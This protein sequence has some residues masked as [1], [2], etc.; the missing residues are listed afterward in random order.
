M[1]LG[2]P[3]GDQNIFNVLQNN[4]FRCHILVSTTFDISEMDECAI[5]SLQMCQKGKDI[6][7]S[8]FISKWYVWF[9]ICVPP[10]MKI[11]PVL[12]YR[13]TIPAPETLA[14]AI[15]RKSRSFG[16]RSV[17]WN[18]CPEIVKVAMSIMCAFVSCLHENW[19]ADEISDG[20]T[21]FIIQWMLVVSDS[22][23]LSMNWPF[24]IMIE[25]QAEK[26]IL[27]SA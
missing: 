6:W 26:L 23:D 16:K 18:K 4:C 27:P 2:Y 22:K 21:S 14:C 7:K 20:H 5:E 8:N 25:W 11:I 10:R 24:P 15:E 3:L 13:H 12:S 1:K 19:M 17:H 9:V